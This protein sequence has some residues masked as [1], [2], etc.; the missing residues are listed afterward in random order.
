MTFSWQ[1]DGPSLALTAALLALGAGLFVLAA[2]QTSR[3][4][5]PRLEPRM[6]PWML[7]LLTA[8]AFLLVMTVHL[9]NLLGVETGPR[10]F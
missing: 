3:P 2:W 5:E 8:A 1:D 4:R 6:T 10:G 7:I 9:V